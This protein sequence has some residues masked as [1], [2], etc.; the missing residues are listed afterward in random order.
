YTMEESPEF[1]T[2]AGWPGQGGRWTDLSLAAIE[3][4]NRELELPLHGL[5][6]IDRAALSPADQLNYD[7]F[8]RNA[9]EGLEGR[10][11]KAE[12]LPISQMQGPQQD[13]ARM[14]MLAASGAARVEDFED[15]LARL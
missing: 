4:R 9:K 10:R 13:V 15:M 3:R 1:A 14:L 12:Y 5:D 8:R 7:L 2:Y 6:S 11:F